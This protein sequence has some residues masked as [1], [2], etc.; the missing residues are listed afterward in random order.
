M[1]PQCV[2]GEAEAKVNEEV[3]GEF[4]GFVLDPHLRFVYAYT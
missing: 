1:L 2:M 4:E 3:A